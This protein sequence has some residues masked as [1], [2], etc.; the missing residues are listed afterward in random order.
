MT[1][2]LFNVWYALAQALGF[3]YHYFDLAF[4]RD[5]R[6]DRYEGWLW[7]PKQPKGTYRET[8]HG[9]RYVGYGSWL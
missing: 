7:M 2:L 9:W 5:I 8:R 1:A 6:L 4:V 3:R